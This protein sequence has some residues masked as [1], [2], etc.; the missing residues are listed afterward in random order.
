M[1]HATPFTLQEPPAAA[2]LEPVMVKMLP[3]QVE[4]DDHDSDEIEGGK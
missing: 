3:P 4:A 2:K 1:T